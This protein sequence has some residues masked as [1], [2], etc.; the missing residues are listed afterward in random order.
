MDRP[1]YLPKKKN[2]K[3]EQQDGLWWKNKLAVGV[4]YMRI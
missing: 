3:E 1:L 4:K 2:W